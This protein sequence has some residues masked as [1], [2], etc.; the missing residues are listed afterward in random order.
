M[1]TQDGGDDDGVCDFEMAITA[2][3]RKRVN[4]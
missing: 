2:M 1:F 4:L 3:R